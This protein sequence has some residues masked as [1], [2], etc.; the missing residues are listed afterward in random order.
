MSQSLPPLLGLSTEF[1]HQNP[2]KIFL[3]VQNGPIC[4]K[5][6]P[7][8]SSPLREGITQPQCNNQQAIEAFLL[9]MNINISGECFICFIL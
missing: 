8:P 3:C 2:Q 6:I 5:I 4:P 9:K 7:V 1:S